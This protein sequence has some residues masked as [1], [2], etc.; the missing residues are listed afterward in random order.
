[1][2]DNRTLYSLK[3]PGS[4]GSGSALRLPGRGSFP[5]IDDHLVQPEVTRDEIVGGRRIVAS[6]AKLA[7]AIQHS[8]LNYVLQ[9]HIAPGYVA[10]VHLLT[11]RTHHGP[12][13]R[14]A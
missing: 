4:P 9:A 5:G 3:A 8:R 14:A 7:Q 13:G 2:D 6:P 10:A 1:M 12:S 11:A